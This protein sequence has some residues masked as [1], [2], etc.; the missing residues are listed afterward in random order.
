MVERLV[1]AKPALIIPPSLI[2]SLEG[3]LWTRKHFLSVD[4]GG[5]GD[6]LE[7]L[8]LYDYSDSHSSQNFRCVQC[9]KG[10]TF[11]VSLFGSDTFLVSFD[12]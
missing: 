1:C 12:S 11:L 4:M 2:S 5:T 9:C 7:L 10:R 3:G 8:G 6:C